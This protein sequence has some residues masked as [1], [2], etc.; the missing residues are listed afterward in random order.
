[1]SQQAG[2]QVYGLIFENIVSDFNDR[3][4]ELSDP[5]WSN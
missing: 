1:L 5:T 2:I 4:D 3:M